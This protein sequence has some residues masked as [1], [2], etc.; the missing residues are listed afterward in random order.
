MNSSNY[1]TEFEKLLTRGYFSPKLIPIRKNAFEQFLT[2]DLSSKKWDHLRFTNLSA[3][4]KNNFRIS[5][6][7]DISPKN[8]KYPNLL[9]K[10]NFYS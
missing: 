10:E 3:L 7:S 6:A 5:N 4:N 9:N 2:R 1:Q 8:F